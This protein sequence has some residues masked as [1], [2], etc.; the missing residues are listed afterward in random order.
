MLAKK[1][2]PLTG[3]RKR[4]QGRRPSIYFYR[5]SSETLKLL[6]SACISSRKVSTR[7]KPFRWITSRA[8]TRDNFKFLLQ[9]FLLYLHK[10]LNKLIQTPM[11]FFSLGQSATKSK[12]NIL[13][14]PYLLLL[15]MARRYTWNLPNS[16]TKLHASVVQVSKQRLNLAHILQ[17]WQKTISE[18]SFHHCSGHL[19]FPTLLNC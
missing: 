9:D 17:L 13:T 7:Y 2:L 10:D 3:Q 16:L 15:L 6:R 5:V 12:C 1:L 18:Q 11:F 14:P 19:W 8:K 4:G